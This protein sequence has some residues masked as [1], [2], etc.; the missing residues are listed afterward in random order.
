[1]SFEKLGLNDTLVETLA[2][3]GYKKPTPVQE[4]AIP[5][6]M[7]DPNNPNGIGDG[8]TNGSSSNSILSKNIGSSLLLQAAEIIFSI[9]LTLLAA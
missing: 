1:M 4:K 2:E 7:P 6:V 8:K 5:V 3:L 9:S